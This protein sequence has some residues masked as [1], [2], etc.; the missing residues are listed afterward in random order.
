LRHLCKS[1]IHRAT[2]TRCDLHDEGDCAIDDELLDAADIRENDQVHTWNA[3]GSERTVACASRAA[4]A[5][6]IVCLDRSAAR[7]ASVGDLILV[8]AF[9][10]AADSEP[11][12][13]PLPVFVGAGNRQTA[14]RQAVAVG[15]AGMSEHQPIALHGLRAMHAQREKIGTPTR[16]D[17]TSAR[18]LDD[19]GIDLLP[20]VE[21]FCTLAM[22]SREPCHP[23]HRTA[24]E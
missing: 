7:C 6:G 17:A 8:A 5:I 4:G 24:H 23:P 18:V 13:P 16:L 3:A 21:S 11:L 20:A 14:L 22:P 12:P 9:G 1:R 15:C 10:A 19:A 2:V